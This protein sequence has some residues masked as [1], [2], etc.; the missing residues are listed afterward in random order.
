MSE[1]VEQITLNK[2]TYDN[3]MFKAA[4]YDSYVAGKLV[5][6]DKKQKEDLLTLWTKENAFVEIEEYYK[7]LFNEFKRRIR[8][9]FTLKF[10]KWRITIT[11]KA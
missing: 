10:W 3:L 5:F 2:T 11:R 8:K 1:N 6:A 4:F 7:S 9:K